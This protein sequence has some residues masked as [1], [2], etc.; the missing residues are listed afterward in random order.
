MDLGESEVEGNGRSGGR[1]N[2]NQICCMREE[3]I[4]IK[5]PRFRSIPNHYDF[6][7]KIKYIFIKEVLSRKNKHLAIL[8]IIFLMNF[9]TYW[10][11]MK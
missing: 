11:K 9:F 1:G 6:L 2:Y 5:N 8:T 10:I 3:S 7:N 4:L